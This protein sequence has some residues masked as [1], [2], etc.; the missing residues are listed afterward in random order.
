MNQTILIL[1]REV[2]GYTVAGIQQLVKVTNADVIVIEDTISKLIP[3]QFK[4]EGVKYK[5]KEDFNSKDAL[6]KYCI[7][8][9][10]KLVLCSGW[11]D[12][13]YLAICK[14]YLTSGT[15]TV[16]MFDTQWHGSFRQYIAS[17]A[18]SMYLKKH[19][20][21]MWG[22][23]MRQFEFAKRMGYS[24][25]KIKIG[26]YTC[27]YNLY[28][29]VENNYDSRN[30]LFIGRF[31]KEKGI[32][33]LIE[34]FNILRESFPTWTL[35]LVGNGK[36][37]YGKLNSQIIVKEFKQPFELVN[38]FSRASIFCLPSLYEPWG[39]VLHEAAVA[40]LPILC[41][42]EC[43]ASDSFV[44][45]GYNGLKFEKN[46]TDKLKYLMEKTPNQLREFG[47]NSRK[48]GHDFN[49]QIWAET[50]LAF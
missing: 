3:F 11:L 31:V 30:I 9:N 12:Q 36:L 46:M 18:S 19:F 17:W 25:D 23:G 41:S 20:T 16:C 10:A 35:T 38:E 39:V 1:Y 40:G 28:K 7:S 44:R 4:L 15:K 26:F 22:S 48:L 47:D 32:D 37:D 14:E 50:I 13:D 29:T 5:S 6:K 43:G 45:D 21:F 42:Y 8:L 24:S 34:S 27:D 49:P 2:M 33:R